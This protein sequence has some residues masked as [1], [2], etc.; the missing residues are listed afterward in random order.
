[1][2]CFKAARSMRAPTRTTRPFW[3]SISINS[4][5]VDTPVGMGAVDGDRICCAPIDGGTPASGNTTGT[6]RG[7]FVGIGPPLRSFSQ[8]NSNGGLMPC[9][10]A[11]ADTFVHGPDASATIA[12]FSASLHRR[13]VSD[14][15]SKPRENSSPDISLDHILSDQPSPTKACLRNHARRLWPDAYVRGGRIGVAVGRKRPARRRDCLHRP[16]A[17]KIVAPAVGA[18]RARCRIQ[19]VGSGIAEG[20]AVGRRHVVGDAVLFYRFAPARS[21]VKSTYG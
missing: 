19:P 5:A 16:V 12:C 15:I 9:R 7:A 14:T 1:M 13:R 18:V 10:R 11:T 17:D 21:A 6:K 8:R 20:L 4:A 2:I 3:S